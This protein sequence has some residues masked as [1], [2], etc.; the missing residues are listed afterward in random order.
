MAGPAQPSGQVMELQGGADAPPAPQGYPG[1]GRMPPPM[2]P[3]KKDNT[4]LIIVVIVIVVAAVVLSLPILLYVMVSGLGPATNPGT[5]NPTVV[6]QAQVWNAGNLMVNVQASTGATV[7]PADLTFIVQDRNGI[8]WY[9]GVAGL[10]SLT[11]GTNVNVT[12]QDITDPGR[13]G[14]GDAVRITVTP[15][16][17]TAVQGGRLR[18][19]F[20][21]N[22]IGAVALP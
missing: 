8:T 9:S 2:P 16:T 17:S 3:P 5:N 20:Q 21:S 14:A 11:S 22:E 10:N 7:D 13:V 18:L 1:W 6:L 15:S 12:F 4:V 19:F